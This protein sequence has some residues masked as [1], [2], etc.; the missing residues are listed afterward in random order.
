M[1][2]DW[3]R[4]KAPLAPQDCAVLVCTGRSGAPCPCAQSHSTEPSVPSE[5]HGG[6]S[7]S[8]SLGH[9]DPARP[10]PGWQFN[11]APGRVLRVQGQKSSSN[12][13]KPSPTCGV[14]TDTPS[15]SLCPP[16]V[17]QVRALGL[18]VQTGV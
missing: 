3:P 1:H 15:L 13:L 16:G 17:A 8:P 12:T 10:E 5:T 14:Q 11:G 2:Q 18:M 6:R 4:G 9:L 7:P